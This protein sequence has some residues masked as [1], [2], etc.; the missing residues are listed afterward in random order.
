VN[1]GTKTTVVC[2]VWEDMKRKG[3][4][5]LIRR[6]YTGNGR[7]HADGR[8]VELRERDLTGRVASSSA[9]STETALHGNDC[10]QQQSDSLGQVEQLQAWL[11]EDRLE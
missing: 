2:S 10:L 6:T 1:E 5:A 7:W 11:A 8:E 4:G 3:A 9:A